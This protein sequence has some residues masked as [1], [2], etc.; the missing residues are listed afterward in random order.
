MT[1]YK[2]TYYTELGYCRRSI[3]EFSDNLEIATMQ[4]DTW[5]KALGLDLYKIEIYAPTEEAL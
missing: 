2:I 5:L 1:T 3:K 4:A